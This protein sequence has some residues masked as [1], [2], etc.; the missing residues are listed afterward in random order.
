MGDQA[1]MIDL[2]GGGLTDLVAQHFIFLETNW[3]FSFVYKHGKMVRLQH[4]GFIRYGTLCFVLHHP[5]LPSL[6]SCSP[7]TPQRNTMQLFNRTVED[8]TVK[9]NI[10][11][12]RQAKLKILGSSSSWRGSEPYDAA[13]LTCLH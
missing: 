2:Q 3:K 12:C 4:T 6:M 9:E 10:E 1:R 5:I 13:M 7:V 11:K 8:P